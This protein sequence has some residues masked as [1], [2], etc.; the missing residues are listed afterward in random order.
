MKTFGDL[1]LQEIKKLFA[2]KKEYIASNDLIGLMDLKKNYSFLFDPEQEAE[3]NKLLDYIHAFSNLPHIQCQLREQQKSRLIEVNVD[4]WDLEEYERLLMEVPVVN[5]SNIKEFSRALVRNSILISK[6]IFS[7]THIDDRNSDFSCVGFLLGE[8]LSFIDI[9][10]RL[11]H[12]K[13]IIRLLT[14]NSSFSSDEGES[15]SIPIEIKQTIKEKF[16]DQ[17]LKLFLKFDKRI[18]FKNDLI[19]FC[20]LSLSVAVIN[21]LKYLYFVK[22]KRASCPYTFLKVIYL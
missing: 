20:F 4:K 8:I 18:E 2:Q 5:I 12:L 11:K 3:Y 22:K 17:C 13:R 15:S 6:H 1:G 10:T 14:G 21:L 7:E 16:K 9:E 19:F